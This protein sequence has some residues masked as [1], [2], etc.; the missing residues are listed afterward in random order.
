MTIRRE[1]EDTLSES[2]VSEVNATDRVTEET[3]VQD[4]HPR[5]RQLKWLSGQR[6]LCPETYRQTP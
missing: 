1:I 2:V 4:W 3:L 5:S 6:R